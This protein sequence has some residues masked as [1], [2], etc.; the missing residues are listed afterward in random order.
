MAKTPEAESHPP[1]DVFSDSTKTLM[2]AI[3]LA[4]WE[5]TAGTTS[6]TAERLVASRWAHFRTGSRIHIVMS[7]G[8]A[9]WASYLARLYITR[10]RYMTACREFTEFRAAN[11]GEHADNMAERMIRQFGHEDRIRLEIESFY[12]STKLLLERIAITFGFFFDHPTKRTGS[13]H[14]FLTEKIKTW[15]AAITRG[16]KTPRRLCE[17]MKELQTRVVSF[18]NLHIEHPSHP[19]VGVRQWTSTQTLADGTSYIS[20]SVVSDVSGTLQSTV[21]RQTKNPADIIALVEEYIVEMLRYFDTY[22]NASIFR[23]EEGTDSTP[24]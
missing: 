7:E 16:Q 4:A 8:L 5:F 20:V 17:L 14:H 22:R 12:V 15:S 19:T 6:Q 11:H 3:Y 2:T 18:R 10:G 9:F 24:K 1:D 23:T 13:A 21:T